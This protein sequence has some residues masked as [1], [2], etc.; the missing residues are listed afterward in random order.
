MAYTVRLTG[1]AQ[2]L[3]RKLPEDVRQRVIREAKALGD[4]P[5]ATG[6]KLK[7]EWADYW[8]AEVGKSYRIVYIIEGE[9]VRITWVG[10]R[11]KAPYD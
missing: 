11:E 3:L 9:V 10:T 4:D 2:K 5:H 6:R 7:G 8:R 1:K